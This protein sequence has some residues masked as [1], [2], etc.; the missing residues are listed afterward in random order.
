MLF[1]DYLYFDLIQNE[2]IQ[3]NK[4]IIAFTIPLQAYKSKNYEENTSLPYSLAFPYI[5]MTFK[6]SNLGLKDLTRT[7]KA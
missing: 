4:L 1:L 7:I 2:K 3:T 5:P 6:W